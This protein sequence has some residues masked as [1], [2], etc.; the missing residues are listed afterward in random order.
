MD[1]RARSDR[2]RGGRR[3]VAGPQQ[4]HAEVA[5]GAA[6]RRIEGERLFG[7]RGGF[8]EA[9]VAGGVLPR[10]AVDLAVR[11]ID[12][13]CL[14]DFA[15]EGGLV[16]LHVGHRRE[17]RVRFELVRIERQDLVDLGPRLGVAIRVEMQAG[18]QEVRIGEIGI[19]RDRLR[20]GLGRLGRILVLEHPRDARVRRRPLGVRLERRLKG[21]Q[22][23]ARIVF[24]EEQAA[25]RRLDHR[26]IGA[27]ALGIDVERLGLARTV[28]RVRGACR[29]QEDVGIGGRGALPVDRREDRLS[30][31]APADR[32]IQQ[33]ELQRRLPRRLAH[34]DRFEHRLRVAVLAARRREL[35]EHNRGRRIRRAP[36][37]RQPLRVGA[38]P[39][40]DRGRRG[41]R[42]I[43]LTCRRLRP[44]GRAGRSEGD[45]QN[46][47]EKQPCGSGEA[48]LHQF[49]PIIDHA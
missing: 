24:F 37:R 13:E 3:L 28:E 21:V 15:V 1:P 9:V 32:A 41:P 19:D 33:R 25:E 49:R 42:E 20:G 16:V 35:R 2:G 5:G 4:V 6:A 8:F 45:E 47:Y 39:M 10:E 38:L 30:V 34:D 43:P 26:R 40:R 7:E 27:G 12:L 48:T 17:H 46:Q 36:R 11:R 29:A 44:H 14:R 31:A 22:R 23:F 18:E